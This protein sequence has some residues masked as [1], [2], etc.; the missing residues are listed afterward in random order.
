MDAFSIGEDRVA[1]I[2]KAYGEIMSQ[3]LPVLK[4]INEC[5]AFLDI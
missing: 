4:S 2:I 3:T 5:H 1:Q